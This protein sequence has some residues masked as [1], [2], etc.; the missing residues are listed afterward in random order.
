MPEIGQTISHYTI[1]EKLGGGGMGVVYKA[2]DTRLGR[3]VAL[4]FL[5]EASAGDRQAIERFK[6]E[7]RAASALNHPNLCTIHD[8]GEHEGRHFIAMELLEGKTLKQRIQG[9]PLAQDEILNIAIQVAEGLEAAHDKGI[10]HRDIKPANIFVTDRG[11]AKILDFGL[12]KLAPERGSAG[13][14][15]Q[16]MATA[17]TAEDSLTSPGA[18]VGT[19]AYMSPEQ[20]LGQELDARTD[21][22][23]LGV[24]IYEMATGVLPFRGSTSAATFDAILHKAPTAPIRI[25]PDLPEDLERIINK[26]LEKDRK[27]RYQHAS[28]LHA[29]LQRLK[30]DSD[31]GRTPAVAA[32]ASSRGGSW[33]WRWILAAV[34]AT[35]ILGLAGVW[36]FTPRAPALTSAD[37]ILLADF[38]NRTGDQE[39]D[40]LLEPA[41]AI[42]LE[43]T[44]FIN[45][46][47][48]ER[49]QAALRYMRRPPGER[50]TKEIGREICERQGIKALLVPAIARLGIRYVITLETYNG[51][52]GDVIARHQAE[53]ENKE[54][55]RRTLGEAASQLRAKLGESLPSIRRFDAPLEQATTSSL[56]AWK[57][58]CLGERLKQVGQNMESIPFYLQAI[59]RD[60]DFAL[61]HARLSAQYSNTLQ[62]GLSREYAQKAY[63]LKDRVSE[64][65][66]LY[67][68]LHFQTSDLNKYTEISELLT[69]MYPSDFGGH[70]ALGAAYRGRGEYEKALVEFQEANRLN[71]DHVAPYSNMGH[72]LIYLNR[73]EEAQKIL[74]QALAKGLETTSIRTYL[75]ELAFIRGDAAAMQKQI[76]WAKAKPEEHEIVFLQSK[77][78]AA[79]GHFLQAQ[80]FYERAVD[81]AQGRNMKERATFFANQFVAQNTVQHAICGACPCAR[82]NAGQALA[83]SRASSLGSAAQAFAFCGDIG[84]AQALA[85]ELAG[86][87]KSTSPADGVIMALIEMQ[88]GKPGEVIQLIPRD[89]NTGAMACYVRG[90]AYLNQ[91]LVAEASVEFQDIIDRG[92]KGWSIT[93]PLA[94]LG[95]A[96]AA[97]ALA[98]DTAKSRKMYEAFLQLWKDAD[99][100]IP[101]LIAAK[102]EYAKLQ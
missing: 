102:A 59:D 39:F 94:H 33:R 14:A 7:A 57:A 72:A 47:P 24:V 68:T 92:P 22:F 38:V 81:L 41:L 17:E 27:L 60:P 19:M 3:C 43:Q 96:R 34:A 10:L 100:D 65:E 79:A 99:P 23:S 13:E 20:A 29:D 61:A 28:D 87:A 98:G 55:V 8:I 95:L 44:P 56:E 80:K 37:T 53:A 42:A 50:I 78:A 18:A 62:M 9:K 77:T 48:E 74:D 69:Q 5:H 6:R 70:T 32:A 97:A 67:I 90:L 15:A 82:Q 31:S 84:K 35:V 89:K 46:V 58:F 45:I 71:P 11:H 75:Y 40:G 4:K 16:A 76:A 63:D 2:E 86:S 30:R 66:R 36:Y 12:A 51:R 85:N 52:T 54:R 64:R 1:L 73:F 93:Y 88:R 91:R 49:V 26:A 101:I 21:L 25:N 83:M